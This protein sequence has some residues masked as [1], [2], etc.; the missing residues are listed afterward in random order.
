MAI[1]QQE[2]MKNI[3]IFT[4]LIQTKGSEKLFLHSKATNHCLQG[5]IFLQ[6]VPDLVHTVAC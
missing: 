2:H 5:S 1:G 3:E 4:N 6:R